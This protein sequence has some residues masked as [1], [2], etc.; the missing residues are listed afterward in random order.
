[1]GNY[2]L[3]AEAKND[4][5]RIYRYGVETHGETKADKYFSG[6]FDRFD[7]LAESPLLYAAV[8]DIRESYRRS[9][10][11]TDSIYYRIDGQ[12]VEIIAIIGQQDLDEWL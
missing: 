8:D 2:R 6:F 5:R 1:M 3:T 10:Y 9:V 12:T 4:L 11:G 7:E